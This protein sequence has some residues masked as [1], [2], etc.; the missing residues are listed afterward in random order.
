[1]AERRCF[2]YCA[3]FPKDYVLKKDRLIKLW[4][5][6]GFLKETPSRDMEMDGEECFNNLAKR[7]FFQDF[8][9][10]QDGRVIECKMH[11]IVH[12]FA[13]FLTK[14]ECFTMELNGPEE[15][16][17][18]SSRVKARHTMMVVAQNGSIPTSICGVKKLRSLIVES[19][20]QT[21]VMNN[22]EV[23]ELFDH[24]TCLRSLELSAKT[25]FSEDVLFQQ[26]AKS[27]EKLIHLRYL[28]LSQNEMLE[29][30]P[31]TV[32]GLFNLQSLNL[33][34][35]SN[36]RRLP[37]GLGNLINLRYL[38]C[39]GTPKVDF[40][41]SGIGR[42]SCLRTLDSFV[43]CSDDNVKEEVSTLEDLGKLINLRNL[44]IKR[45]GN[46]KDAS[47]AEKAR[48][49]NKKSLRRL[50]LD[51]G[52]DDGQER[53]DER[54]MEAIQPPPSL[55]ELQLHCYR[56]TSLFPNNWITMSLTNLKKVEINRC[57]CE[58]LPTLRTLPSLEYLTIEKLKKVKR[59]GT[60]FW[61]IET[62]DIDVN[63]EETAL[64]SSSGIAFPKLEV[65]IFIGMEEWEEWDYGIMRERREERFQLMP[66]LR[67]L[68]LYFCPKL[69]QLPDH[70]LRTASLED[71]SIW[72]CPAL[73]ERYYKERTGQDWHKISHIP[74]I[75]FNLAFVQGS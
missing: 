16:V 38:E 2:S 48:L 50:H 32:C 14:N 57:L 70:L 4:M 49:D 17:V 63:E 64:S 9:N 10:D 42:L 5:A 21:W 73:E 20:S 43:V 51:F 61:G 68:R 1:M 29:Q 35:C 59:V 27:V 13:Q 75:K 19:M 26:L 25:L 71:L 72:A 23:H 22:A 33:N 47:E 18:D 62:D 36:L 8:E 24:L 66:C 60:E 39:L 69:K 31:E 58:V 40:M 44:S 11:D 56:G 6:Q 74:S 54:V 28:N 55:E 34:W 7:S 67:C 65:L 3:I 37:R 12:D 15:S 53:N 45:L 46:V 41:P 52:E 30:L